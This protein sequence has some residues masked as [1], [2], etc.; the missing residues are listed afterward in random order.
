V[1]LG[2]GSGGW[3]RVDMLKNCS[4]VDHGH[5][6]LVEISESARSAFTVYELHNVAML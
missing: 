4:V 2:W 5:G 3:I 6:V 1:S